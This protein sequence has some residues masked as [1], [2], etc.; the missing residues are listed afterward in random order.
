MP[1]MHRHRPR[2]P[3]S[4][5][6]QAEPHPGTFPDDE[7]RLLLGMPGISHGVLSRIERAGVYSLQAL[8]DRGV[9]AVV[10]QVCLGFGSFAWRNRRRAL[11]RA[12]A[13]LGARVPA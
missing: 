1:T 11:A 6:G 12:L 4:P 5:E 7:R 10:D 13:T 3:L 8:L 9:D 2:Y